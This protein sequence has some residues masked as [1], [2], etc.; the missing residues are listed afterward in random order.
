MCGTTPRA[1]TSTMLEPRR[2]TTH[3]MR[4]CSAGSSCDVSASCVTCLRRLLMAARRR[5]VVYLAYSPRPS[6]PG[7]R[8]RCTRPPHV[9]VQRCRGG[10]LR[11]R[12]AQP[13]DGCQSHV[14][15]Q[16]RTTVHH[17]R[18]HPRDLATG[19]PGCRS[20]GRRRRVR[21]LCPSQH[22]ATLVVLNGSPPGFVLLEGTGASPALAQ[23]LPRVAQL[24]PARLRRNCLLRSR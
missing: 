15:R 21:S 17:I 4:S 20:S 2:L 18:R 23:Q 19:C 24:S 7:R 12:Q 16:G 14:L 22:P 8:R 9:K 3:R 6:P 5:Y 11:R 13:A 10:V 1:R